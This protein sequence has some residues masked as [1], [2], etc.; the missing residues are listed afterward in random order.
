MSQQRSAEKQ[1]YNRKESILFALPY[2]I[3]GGAEHVQLQL[4]RYLTAHGFDLAI[5]TSIKPSKGMGDSTPKFEGATKEIYHLYDFLDNEK[6]Y[7]LF[8][9]YLLKSRKIDIVFIAGCNVVYHMLPQIREKYPRIRVIDQLYNEYGH[10]QNNRRY[11]GYID[12]NI[13]ENERVQEALI[14]KYGES[15]E[16]VELIYNGVDAQYF[17][18]LMSS[19]A[20]RL[21]AYHN[22]PDNKFIVSFMGR[23]W[24]EKAPDIFVE[25]IYR[26]RN[27]DELFFV[28]AGDGPLLDETR[29]KVMHM[30]L[31]DRVLLPGIVD[32][33]QLLQHTN[34]LVLPSRIDGRP[35]AV[36][37][38]LAMGVPVIASDIGGLPQMIRSGE[39]GYI[40]AFGD[41]AG[42]AQRIEMM[43]ANRELAE[44]LGRN[45]RAYAVEHLD[46]RVMLER[47]S[48]I[49]SQLLDRSNKQ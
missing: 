44:S 18:P 36:L 23:F 8:I 12:L 24:E 41:I 4:A 34:V 35:N 39:N 27:D 6:Q 3:V 28:M 10:I 45:A 19:D 46:I 11:C 22:I 15:P 48:E 37:E 38:A 17:K 25:V 31:E 30:G 47:Y 26:L 29:S 49:F 14:Q 16:R 32:A 1:I 5:I 13:V 33:K 40:C 20:T 9:E 43:H 42:I 7:R 21:S 2:M